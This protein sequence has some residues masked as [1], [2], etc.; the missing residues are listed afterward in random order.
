MESAKPGRPR[1]DEGEARR[2]SCPACMYFDRDREYCNLPEL[3]VA[4][5]PEWL[6]IRWRF[7]P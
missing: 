1:A 3:A 4:E 7:K 5:Q 6:R 2:V